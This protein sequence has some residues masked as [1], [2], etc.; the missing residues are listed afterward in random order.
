MK[1]KKKF[2][3]P[4]LGQLLVYKDEKEAGGLLLENLTLGT[5]RRVQKIRKELLKHYEEL[6]EDI[7]DIKGEPEVMER[8]LGILS[9][10]EVEITSELFDINQLDNVSSTANYDFEL[11]EMISKQ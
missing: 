9:E 2:I 7:K 1:L 11:L 5:K 3:I 6:Q 4:L 8:E 10:E